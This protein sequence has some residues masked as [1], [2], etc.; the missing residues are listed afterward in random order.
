MDSAFNMFL[1]KCKVKRDLKSDIFRYKGVRVCLC[2][3]PSLLPLIPKMYH[4][5]YYRND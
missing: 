1:A 4:N 5:K 2:F 3:L